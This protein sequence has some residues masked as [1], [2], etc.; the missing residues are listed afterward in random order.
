M[1]DYLRS[2]RNT[3]LA[4]KLLLTSQSCYQKEDLEQQKGYQIPTLS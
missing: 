2:Y 3:D 1:D 4:K